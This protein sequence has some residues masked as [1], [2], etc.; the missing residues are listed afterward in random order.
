MGGSSTLAKASST[1]M[2]TAPTGERTML[3]CVGAVTCAGASRTVRR[4]SNLVTIGCENPYRRASLEHG[5]GLGLGLR[6]ALHDVLFTVIVC[7]FRCVELVLMDSTCGLPVDPAPN[8]HWHCPARN[9]SYM[10][11]SCAHRRSEGPAVRSRL[12]VAFC[13]TCEDENAYKKE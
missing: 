13:P 8:A 9:T 7:R 1:A 12:D 2:G 11:L 10:C 3:R 5:L 6:L 4:I